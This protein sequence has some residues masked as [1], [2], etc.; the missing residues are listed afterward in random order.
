[1]PDL[2][3]GTITFLFSD[4]EGSTQLLSQL[5]DQYA[6]L[7]ADQ[8]RILREAF[9]NWHGQE[10]DTQG[11]AFF[12][13]FPRATQA[14]CAVVEIQRALAANIWP[15]NVEV[16]V[17]MGLHTGEPLKAEEG[18]VGMDV[19]RAA[20]IAHVGHGGQVLLSETSAALVRDELPHGVTLLDLGRH[21]LK[22]LHQ[23]E[24]IRQLVIEGLPSEFPHL[25]SLEIL[26][27]IF[28]LDEGGI[29]LPDFLE[30]E[31]KEAPGPVF[32][33]RKRELARL[34]GFLDQVQ[35]GQG[36]VVF[37]T[38]GP[39]QGK[40]AL[41]TEFSR[42]VMELQPDLLVARG[43][44][45]SYSGVGD[46]YLP[47]RD[48]LA[49]LTGDVESRY[50]AGLISAELARRLWNILPEVISAIMDSGL[51]LINRLLSARDLLTRAQQIGGIQPELLGRLQV[52]V[53]G[54]TKPSSLPSVDQFGL[55]GQ[56]E[57]VLGKL[58]IHRPLVLILDDLQWMDIGSINLLFH[59]GRR[60]AGSQIL[61][62]G[63]YRPADVA[64]GRD[65]RRH[66]LE[67]L[68]S[69]FKRQYGDIWIDLDDRDA[70]QE[71]EFVEE[72]L[73]KN[74]NRLSPTFRQALY[75]HT[76]GHP[77]FT[78]E[79]LR[80]L[81]EQG[82][83]A[84]D[85]EG[86]WFE[87]G[88]INW[89][90]IPSKVEGVIEE[91]IGR[92]EL[93]K[94]DILTIASVEGEEF[95]AQVIARIRNLDEHGLF[96][97]LSQS[98]D[99][100]HRLIQ[101]R[102]IERLGD[103]LLFLFTFR[104]NLFQKYLYEQLNE[105]ERVVYHQ[106]VG[107]A[108]ETLYIGNTE[109]ISPQLAR[110][111]DLAGLA[112]KAIQ[113]YTMAGKYAMRVSAN[114]EAIAHIQHAIDLLRIL[115]DS[116][117]R[118][119]RE[120][121]LQLLLPP[122][123][124]AVKGWAAPELSAVY[125]RALELCSELTDDT[126]LIRTLWLLAVYRM[127]RSEHEKV[128]S[129]IEQLA[130]IAHKTGDPRWIWMGKYKVY[131]F[132]QGF[133]QKT[134]ENL[135]SVSRLYE[136]N[137]ARSLAHLYGMA[138][139][140]V[141]EAYLSNCLWL[142]GFPEKALNSTQ[143]ALRRAEEINVPMSKCYVLSRSCWLYMQLDDFE[144]VRL[145]AEELYQISQ[146]HRFKSFELGATFY[147]QAAQVQTGVMVGGELE[148]IYQ[149]MEAFHA[150]GTILNHTA[151]LVLYAE[152]CARI[153]EFESGLAAANESISLGDQTGELW[154]QAEAYRLKGELLARQAEEKGRERAAYTEAEK[155]FFRAYEIAKIQNARS[156]ELRAAISLFRLSKKSGYPDRARHGFT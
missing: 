90:A 110:H 94:R 43:S 150:M 20:R 107:L 153:K 72:Y 5:R 123:L 29:K 118:S 36:R 87:R 89:Q 73:D 25:K 83:L 30:Q 144:V 98:L 96:Q 6:T 131:Q 38:G 108:L 100:Q 113:Y 65:G 34:Q 10:V 156:L 26:P 124:T 52:S 92:L 12:V 8:R 88:T 4:I 103:N 129:L 53:L 141:G 112:D 3:E 70:R 119:S 81:Q 9:A 151:Y 152:A 40:T 22:D 56:F 127:G 146:E 114:H 135:E 133:F 149:A 35:A 27:P 66:P 117:E 74:P 28:S 76:E 51:D 99:R 115:P 68:L 116:P 32:V 64:L 23:S 1:M 82:D 46:P 128:N 80:N 111:F 13:A 16:R 143:E 14:V 105:S 132:Y 78:I 21:L 125:D 85:E 50:T 77:L 93:A 59:L 33:G 62:V 122:S 84:F 31:T 67:E 134:R 39:G 138:P 15:E 106:E 54:S 95:T 101:D 140:V 49:M 61:L 17:R 58:A 139:S 86:R 18:Y 102:G 79:L 154:I 91:R 136:P 60:L 155:C 142:L 109:K 55:F 97:M 41:M 57:N 19:H 47:F 7:L 145:Q 69:E 44:C 48:I 71:Q 63:A 121:D 130:I 126:Q 148:R 45:D 24:H 11:D 2:P 75:K 104:H 137:E 147:I 120:L 37:I 42:R